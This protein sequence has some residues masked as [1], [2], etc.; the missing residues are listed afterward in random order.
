ML[1]DRVVL[2]TGA[3][4]G[5]DAASAKLLGQHGAA[6]GVNYYGS[7]MALQKQEEH[8]K[9][10]PAKKVDPEA[11]MFQLFAKNPTVG[12][13]GGTGVELVGSYD[14]LATIIA[15]FVD[16]GIETFVLQFNPFAE[17]ITRFAQEIIPRLR[18]LQLVA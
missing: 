2:I 9:L 15:D 17:E 6:V 14:T 12:G 8:L 16:A 5:I 10:S 13:N 18:S 11:V 4:R 1:R 3:S 7:E